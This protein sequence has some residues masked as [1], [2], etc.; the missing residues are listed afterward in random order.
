YHCKFTNELLKQKYYIIRVHL[1]MEN[2]PSAAEASAFF[3][4]L[5]V[6]RRYKWVIIFPAV[7]GSLIA[8]DYNRTLKYKAEK[9]KLAVL[10]NLT[11]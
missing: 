1:Y 8:Y 6:L 7:S 4:Y 11:A 5:R 2:K 3:K 10:N 9:A